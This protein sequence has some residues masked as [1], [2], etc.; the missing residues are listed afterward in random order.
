MAHDNPWRGQFIRLYP[1]QKN[2]PGKG[3][4]SQT[5]RRDKKYHTSINRRLKRRGQSRADKGFAHCLWR[6][7]YGV[8]SGISVHWPDIPAYHYL[9][10]K[11]E[12]DVG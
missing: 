6:R 11:D 1:L 7:G 4:D 12:D 5:A 10:I 3:Y 9:Y 2:R 8:A